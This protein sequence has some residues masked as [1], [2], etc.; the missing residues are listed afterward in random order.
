MWHRP[1]TSTSTAERTLTVEAI[2]K[3]GG[4]YQVMWHDDGKKR[5][6][7]VVIDRWTLADQTV[8]DAVADSYPAD[9]CPHV[10]V[11]MNAW[12]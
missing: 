5:K 1:N 6:I 9:D 11:P 10:V 7:L 12:R 8:R 4:V 3:F 2:T